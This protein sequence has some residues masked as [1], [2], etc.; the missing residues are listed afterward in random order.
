VR[1]QADRSERIASDSPMLSVPR[2]RVGPGDFHP[3][4]QILSSTNFLIGIADLRGDG[5]PDYHY[6]AHVLYGDSVSPARLSVNGGAT[7][8][9]G[10]GFEGLAITAG[11]NNIFPLRVNASQM[12]LAMPAQGDGAQSIT[13]TDPVSGAFSTM[14]GA[15]TYGAAATDNL[16]LVAGLNPLT[17]VGVQATDP[18]RV[19][20]V[21]SDGITPVSGEPSPGAPTTAQLFPPV[22]GPRRV[23]RLVMKAAIRPPW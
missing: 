20:V 9:R 8:L 10:T 11:S 16:V 18:V 14:T 5:R 12:I 6:H 4:A 19:R 15:L 22:E 2:R 21:A 17:P 3:D 1:C 23:M 13:I 7:T